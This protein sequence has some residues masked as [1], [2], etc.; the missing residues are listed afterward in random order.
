MADPTKRIRNYIRQY[1]SKEPEQDQEARTTATT[2]KQQTRNRHKPS[3]IP[4]ERFIW[5]MITLIT[6]LIGVI[7]LEAIY[8]IVTKEV[9]NELIA[10]VSGL[11]GSLATAFL[12]GKN[13]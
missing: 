1:F 7:F 12:M 8:I 4:S 10:I 13:R 6:A 9:N 3:N 2:R 5:S 11:I